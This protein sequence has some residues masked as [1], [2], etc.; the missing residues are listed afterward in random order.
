MNKESMIEKA[1]LKDLLSLGGGK[2]NKR[3]ETIS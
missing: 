1:V 2:D 3:I